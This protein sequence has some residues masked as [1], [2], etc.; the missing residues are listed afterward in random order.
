MSEIGMQRI[1]AQTRERPTPARPGALARV[2]AAS[3]Q[4]SRRQLLRTG[5]VAAVGLWGVSVAGAWRSGTAL[6]ANGTALAANGTAL[7]A[8]GTGGMA[9]FRAKDLPVMRAVAGAFLDGALPAGSAG[10]RLDAIDRTV[11]GADRY[12]SAYSP[13]VQAEALQAFDLLGL[14]PVRWLG[15]MWSS[16]ES[17]T[18]AE[19]NGYLERLRTGRLSLARQVFQLVA[20]LAVVGWYGQPAAWGAIGYPGPP[21]PPRPLGER[22]L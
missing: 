21:N 5:A 14:A 20:G 4:P 10:V 2:S 22:P 19:V 3:W 18:P 12:F 11:A 13:A 17:A 15:G 1:A 8:N 16:W 9:F 6:A 7:A